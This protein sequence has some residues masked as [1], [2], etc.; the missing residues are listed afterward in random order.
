MSPLESVSV[1]VDLPLRVPAEDILAPGVEDVGDLDAFVARGGR[2]RAA[3]AVVDL[4]G[5]E[6]KS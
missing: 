5:Q 4:F 3:V 6:T 2:D 1:P